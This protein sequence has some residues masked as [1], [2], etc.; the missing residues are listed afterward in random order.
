MNKNLF[1]LGVFLVVAVLGGGAWKLVKEPLDGLTDIADDIGDKEGRLKAFLRSAEDDDDESTVNILPTTSYAKK[2]R[3]SQEQMKDTFA[4]TVELFDQRCELFQLFWE[5]PKEDTPRFTDR[6]P[7]LAESGDFNAAYRD[8]NND[9][10][11]KYWEKFPAP[12]VDEGEDA[13]GEE[14][15]LENKAPT[16]EM[17][18]SEEI[19]G[20]MPRAMKQ[21][22]ITE[23][24]FAA[25]HQLGIGGLQSV[26][27][28][29]ERARS[30]SRRSTRKKKEEEEETGSKVVYKKVEARV[31]LHMQYSKLQGMLRALYNS[32]QV[33]F[34]EPRIIEFGKIPDSMKGFATYIRQQTF[35]SRALAEVAQAAGEPAAE[36]P[37]VKVIMQLVALDWKEVKLKLAGDG[38]G[39]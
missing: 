21:Y 3:V 7:N 31:V 35:K 4:E 37:P 29:V 15:D 2:I 24:V 23:A 27:F 20:N 25:C 6:P 39:E 17:V 22:M 14:E 34:V 1:G 19:A 9:L 8:G 16:V 12:V 32:P 11:E 28:P 33:P 18:R 38:S 13:A 26:E 10:R 5:L 30:S 36:E